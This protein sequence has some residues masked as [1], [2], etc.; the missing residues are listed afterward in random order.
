[1][2][3]GK[4]ADGQ[5][6]NADM[7]AQNSAKCRRRVQ[8]LCKDA[9][10]ADRRVVA[11]VKQLRGVREQYDRDMASI[12]AQ[13]R[14]ARPAC[15]LQCVA[16]WLSALQMQE[17]EQRRVEAVAGAMRQFF[18]MQQ[19]LLA[20]AGRSSAAVAVLVVASAIL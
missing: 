13:A 17:L 7:L 10:A 2:S 12:L 4:T 14:P 15:L 8:Q 1:M 9:V 20:S 18:G 16:G 3:A 11:D 19:S 6:K 5:D